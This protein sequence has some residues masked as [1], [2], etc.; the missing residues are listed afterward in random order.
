MDLADL[1][2][3][4]EQVEQIKTQSVASLGGSIRQGGTRSNTKAISTEILR[5]PQCALLVRLAL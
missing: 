4:E 3:A 1:P 2:G 5:C